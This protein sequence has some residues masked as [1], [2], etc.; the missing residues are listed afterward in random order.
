MIFVKTY[1]CT[2][3]RGD[4]QSM[5]FFLKDEITG[6]IEDADIVIIN[7]CGVKGQTEH[8]ILKEIDELCGRKK[9][10]VA[11]CLPLIS[12]EKIN[13]GVEAI[14][15][16]SQIGE[17]RDI[18]EKVKRGEKVRKIDVEVG[19]PKVL[20]KLREGAVA[21]VPIS[22]GCKGS[23]SYCATR[24]ARGP[25]RSYSPEDIV[26]DVSLAT[27]SGFKEIELT[28]QDTGCYGLDIGTNL[29]DLVEKV[30]EI[31]G[32]FRIRIGM[33]NPNHA[34][35]L[36]DKLVDVYEN[37]K[38]YKFLHLPVQSGSNRILEKMNRFYAVE[39]Y[40]NI[41]DTFRES[42]PYLYLATDIIVGFPEESD[43]DFEKSVDIIRRSKPDKVNVTRYSPRPNTLAAGLK[44]FPDRIKKDRSRII[45]KEA[46]KISH[47][48][49]RAYVGKSWRALVVET[50]KK[51]RKVA[52]L[53]NYK[54]VICDGNIGE[55]KDVKIKK[56]MPTY[57]VA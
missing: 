6:C 23:C 39:D 44:Q 19:L 9:L 28:S 49:N 37:E 2:L 50:G 55:F 30:C 3:N 31:S 13:P 16:P 43:E 15:G 53:N 7:T 17:I 41:V 54:P 12:F 24:F 48:I 56:A 8:K 34:K 22:L 38:V 25:L 42:F 5:Q 40:C 32:E 26:K 20:P 18:V 11:G 21:I 14:I 51:G 45:S 27:K 29:P 52:R 4:G 1:G 46:R 57:L 33:M 35:I 36:L 47:D 10:I